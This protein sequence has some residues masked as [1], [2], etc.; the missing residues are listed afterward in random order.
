MVAVGWRVGSFPS[1]G[2]QLGVCL[3]G[4]WQECTGSDKGLAREGQVFFSTDGANVGCQRP[5]PAV[6]R[7]TGQSVPPPPPALKAL[8]T[9][10]PAAPARIG[11]G[12]GVRPSPVQGAQLLSQVRH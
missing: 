8:A 3:V 11:V 4:M 7:I 9:P 5:L 12:W 6:A 1:K 10:A 2:A